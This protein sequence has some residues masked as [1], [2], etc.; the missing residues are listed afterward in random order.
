[1]TARTP[2]SH[3][4]VAGLSADLRK[5]VKDLALDRPAPPAR[6][7][8]SIAKVRTEESAAELAGDVAARARLA[9][10]QVRRDLQVTDADREIAR[11]AGVSAEALAAERNP[12]AA[13]AVAALE[14]FIASA[15]S[16][17]SDAILS[18]AEREIVRLTGA[19]VKAYLAAVAERER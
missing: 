18:P 5:L 10:E 15:D 7:D 16:A 13:R 19:D 6:A 9:L 1:V 2:L 4:Q 11:G 3:A 14:T 17:A 12:A 8:A